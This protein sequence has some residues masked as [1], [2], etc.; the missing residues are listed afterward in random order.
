M[1]NRWVHIKMWLF[2]HVCVQVYLKKETAAS[3]LNY[4]T[5]NLKPLMSFLSTPSMP[6][7]TEKS[8]NPLV[9]KKQ[10]T[11]CQTT[12][13]VT[14]R[15]IIQR[16]TK[17]GCRIHSLTRI[18]HLE[19]GKRKSYFLASEEVL[20][21]A[22]SFY[23]SAKYSALL[24]ALANGIELLYTN[25]YYQILKSFWN[26]HKITLNQNLIYFSHKETASRTTHINLINIGRIASKNE[27]NVPKDHYS[28]I[29]II[30]L[31]P[32]TR[33]SRCNN[34]VYVT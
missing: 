23:D 30:S 22:Q 4:F 26:K 34:C 15:Q 14:G 31:L 33:D 13:S 12:G 10:R 17:A 2:V 5:D 25:H 1:T 18:F 20:V 21:S 3:V 16:A 9:I 6:I 29:I 32:I 19:R 11:T 27:W 24:L 7:F 28:S 8:E